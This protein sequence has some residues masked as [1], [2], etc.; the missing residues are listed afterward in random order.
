MKTKISERVPEYLF[1]LTNASVKPRNR[2]LRLVV[3]FKR[4]KS[5]LQKATS[6][7]LFGIFTSPQIPRLLS[8]SCAPAQINYKFINVVSGRIEE[9]MNKTYQH[10]IDVLGFHLIEVCQDLPG[11]LYSFFK[12][13]EIPVLQAP[14]CWS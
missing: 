7:F 10:T 5:F 11:G 4:T 2:R 14:S 8:F 9:V 13:G 6:P 1:T 12:T 3:Q